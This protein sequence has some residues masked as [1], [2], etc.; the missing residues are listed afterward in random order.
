M[1]EAGG[2]HPPYAVCAPTAADAPFARAEINIMSTKTNKPTPAPDSGRDR[3]GR[4][5]KGNRGGPGNPQARQVAELRGAVIQSATKEGV[6][7]IAEKL[8][9]LAAEGNVPA[10]KLYFSYVIGKPS[11][12]ACDPDRLNMHEWDICGEDA[13]I[14]AEMT[15]LC[16]YP[17]MAEMMQLFR[18][19]RGQATDA[20]NRAVYGYTTATPAELKRYDKRPRMND[21]QAKKLLHQMGK[22]KNWETLKAKAEAAAT[23]AAAEKANAAQAKAAAKIAK[24]PSA[25]GVNGAGESRISGTQDG[26]SRDREGREGAE[27]RPLPHGPHGRGSERSDHGAPSVNGTN[28]ALLTSSLDPTAAPSRNGKQATPKPCA[29]KPAPSRNGRKV[30]AWLPPELRQGR[31]IAGNRF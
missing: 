10:I 30:A 13:K 8:R 21:G 7:E 12:P 25:N 24:A 6:L 26:Q 2:F 16:K 5:T 1:L 22:A 4:F 18:V 31:Q 15:P 23:E 20:Q 14:H 19:L 3:N 9:Q 27:P 17:N 11:E 28:G 29:T